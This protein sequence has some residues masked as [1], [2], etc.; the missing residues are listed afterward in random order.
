MDE[1]CQFLVKHMILDFDGEV[2]QESISRL[3]AEDPS[4]LAQSLRSR[5]IEDDGVGD[6]LIVLSDC[7]RDKIRTGV[8]PTNVK[9]QIEIYVES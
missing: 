5:L 7:L 1:L 6:F 3:L 8:T 9:K 2:T 4:P